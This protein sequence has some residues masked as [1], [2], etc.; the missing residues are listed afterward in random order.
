MKQKFDPLLLLPQES[1]LSE[2]ISVN[3]RFYTPYRGWKVEI[4]TGRIRFGDLESLN[5][6]TDDLENMKNNNLHLKSV[7]SWWPEFKLYVKRE[8]NLSSWETIESKEHF[9]MMLTDFL[10]SLDGSAFKPNF[11]F[12][13]E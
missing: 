9:N 7:S 6:L 3:D 8:A 4:F 1:Y 12:K 5:K 11:R 2:F 10:F 13:S